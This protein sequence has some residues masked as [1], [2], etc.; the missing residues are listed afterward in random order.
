MKKGGR[1]RRRSS[2]TFS[3]LLG[4]GAG[5]KEKKEG[6]YRRLFCR[7]RREKA[8]PL[9]LFLPL[10]TVNG[11]KKKEGLGRCTGHSRTKAKQLRI[12]Y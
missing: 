1:E 11:R 10:S 9:A 4:D 2:S 5:K 3:L 8:E 12:S 7:G 6:G